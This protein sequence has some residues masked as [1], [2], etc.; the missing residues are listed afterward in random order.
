M[1]TH[2]QTHKHK[3]PI[4]VVTYIQIGEIK[5]CISNK[6]LGVRLHGVDTGSGAETVFYPAHTLGVK[7]MGV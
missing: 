5:G 7:N 4:K 3:E 1:H 6:L 2:T